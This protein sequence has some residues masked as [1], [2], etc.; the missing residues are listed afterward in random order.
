VKARLLFLERMEDGLQD[1]VDAP[2]QNPEPPK[3]H[4]GPSWWEIVVVLILLLLALGF[5][6]WREVESD[7]EPVSLE[8]SST[9][10]LAVLDLDLQDRPSLNP[11]RET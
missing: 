2:G 11:T 10:S 6:I 9:P 5:F 8:R 7:E 3:D 1:R 4:P